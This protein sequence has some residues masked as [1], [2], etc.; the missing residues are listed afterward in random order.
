MAHAQ[1]P[2]D[3]D[4]A[5]RTPTYVDVMPQTSLTRTTADAPARSEQPPPQ[6][7]PTVDGVQ[8]SRDQIELLKRTIAKGATDDELQ[9]FIYTCRRLKLDPFARQIYAV[10]RRENVGGQWREAMQAQ[11]SIDGF[12]LVAERTGK[13]MGQLPT[14]WADVTESAVEG[15][16]P[17][18]VWYDVWPFARAPYAARVAVLRSDFR[19][20][21]VAVA[22]YDAYVQKT[23]DGAPNSMWTKM[24]A[25]QLAKCAEALALRKAFPQEL[26]GVYTGDEMAQ[27]DNE[28]AGEGEQRQRPTRQQTTRGSSM[29]SSSGDT[30]A[31]PAGGAPTA[32]E[33]AEAPPMLFPFQPHRGVRLDATTGGRDGEDAVEYVIDEG[34]LAKAHEFATNASAGRP[35]GK[36]PKIVAPAERE[37][38]NRLALAIEREIERRGGEGDA[39]DVVAPVPPAEP[40][41]D[42]EAG[43]SLP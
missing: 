23:R 10:K 2:Q 17:R 18:I 41:L 30:A 7:T 25:E 38:W 32:D 40:T 20:P 9:L 28:G 6:E 31:T 43:A 19:E 21:L 36:P 26:S 22:R 33:A 34:T 3:V 16:A 24:G 37:K 5:T 14:Q 15:D 4:T 1:H 42:S 8:F 27:A 13:Y 12:R 29:R 11:T 39:D 35:V